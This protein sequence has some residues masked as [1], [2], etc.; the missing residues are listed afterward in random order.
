MTA[1]STR[2]EETS[3]TIQKLIQ[4]RQKPLYILLIYSDRFK[5]VF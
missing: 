2:Q 5:Y 1:F 4:I 3:Q